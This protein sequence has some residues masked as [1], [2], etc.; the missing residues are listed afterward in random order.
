MDIA[1]IRRI[2]EKSVGTP[3]REIIPSTMG[4]PLVYKHM[5]EI[6]DL[7][8]QFDVKLISQPMVPFLV[9]VP[10]RGPKGLSQ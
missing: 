6:I 1:L 10:E 2:L 8:Y 7:C 4:E 9:V 3:L 5:D